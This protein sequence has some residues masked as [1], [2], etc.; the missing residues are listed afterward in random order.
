MLGW[1]KE[2]FGITP[3]REEPMVLKTEQRVDITPPEIKK[4]A[5]KPKKT[6]KVQ[7]IDLES[8]GKN[9]LLAE[10]KKRGVK[11]NASLKKEE[12]LARIKNA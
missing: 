6:A 11:A 1:F 2:V 7:T 3:K 12:I 10:A 4:T 9:E 5:T 8:L